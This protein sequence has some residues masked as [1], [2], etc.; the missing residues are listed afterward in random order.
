ML[1]TVQAWVPSAY[2]AFLDYR[3]G[4]VTLSG[5]MRAVVRRMLSGEQVDQPGSGLSKREWTE[6]MEAIGPADPA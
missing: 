2:Q 1:G 6:L 5:T 4:A 3:L